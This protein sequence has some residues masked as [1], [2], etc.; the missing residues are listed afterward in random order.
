MGVKIMRPIEFKGSNTIFAKDQPEYL[1]L[2]AY[3]SNNK[4][5]EVTSCWKLSLKERFKVLL[6]GRMYFSVWTFNKKLQ[7]QRP[8][9][10][11]PVT[12]RR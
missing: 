5:G 4:E 7:P 2:P 1:P 3:K 6:R 11:N 10:D 9:V 12:E 8:S